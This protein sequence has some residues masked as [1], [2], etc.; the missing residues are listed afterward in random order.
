MHPMHA[1]YS[2]RHWLKTAAAVTAAA[3]TD[4]LIRGRRFRAHATSRSRPMHDL[5]SRSY[6]DAR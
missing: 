5:R 2:R 4:P 6:S 3:F 1:C